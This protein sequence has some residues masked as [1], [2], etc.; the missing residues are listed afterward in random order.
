MG[1]LV[2]WL[3]D[4]GVGYVERNAHIRFDAWIRAPPK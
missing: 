2:P 3:E 1:A 4:D